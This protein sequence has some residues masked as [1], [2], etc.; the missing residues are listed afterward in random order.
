MRARANLF[1]LDFKKRRESGFCQN[2]LLEWSGKLSIGIEKRQ[3]NYTE[4]SAEQIPESR[5]INWEPVSPEIF[6]RYEMNRHGKP[7]DLW[8]RE[9]IL[10]RY[11]VCWLTVKSLHHRAEE[12]RWNL[13]RFAFCFWPMKFFIHLFGAGRNWRK[14]YGGIKIYAEKEQPVSS[15][16]RVIGGTASSSSSFQNDR[17]EDDK[18]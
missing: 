7:T 13:A 6:V 1:L 8:T 16:Q 18:G 5:V 4:W 2:A 10:V 17:K 9:S 12:K 3:S 14:L 11:L 15:S